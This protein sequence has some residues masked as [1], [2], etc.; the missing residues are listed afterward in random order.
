VS[1]LIEAGLVTLSVSMLLSLRENHP[2]EDHPGEN[3]SGENHPAWLQR[4]R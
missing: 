2:R 4:D 1:L 3:H